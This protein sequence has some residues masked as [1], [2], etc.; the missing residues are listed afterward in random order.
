MERKV[1]DFYKGT[2]NILWIKISVIIQ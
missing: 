1:I 2:N